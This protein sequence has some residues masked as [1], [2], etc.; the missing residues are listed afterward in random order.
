MNV[1]EILINWVLLQRNTIMF[2]QKKLFVETLKGMSIK[3]MNT[4][5]NCSRFVLFSKYISI[6]KVL[7]IK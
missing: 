6:K 3:Y 5:R 1:P 7:A 4:I 2:C